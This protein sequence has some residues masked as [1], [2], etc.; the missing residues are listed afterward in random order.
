MIE[1]YDYERSQRGS[2]K[3]MKDMKQLI[4]HVRMVQ[5]PHAISRDDANVQGAFACTVVSS[6]SSGFSHMQGSIMFYVAATGGMVFI[7]SSHT[8][9]IPHVTSKQQH[10]ATAGINK[11]HRFHPSLRTS[12]RGHGGSCA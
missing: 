7:T 1:R 5:R 12:F 6:C 4:V 9:C 2:I 10:S 8:D 11:F 3:V